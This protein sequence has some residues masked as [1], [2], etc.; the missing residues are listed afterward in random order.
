MISKVSTMER[1]EGP[2]VGNGHINSNTEKVN[3]SNGHANGHTNTSNG[4]TKNSNGH[5]KNSNGHANGSNGHLTTSGNGHLSPGNGQPVSG[6]S[7]T[8]SP[9]MSPSRSRRWKTLKVT[10]IGLILTLGTMITVLDLPTMLI[11]IIK[12]IMVTTHSTL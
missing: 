12:P 11:M 2:H 3:T 9:S 5:A 7:L 1:V 4:H 6:T 10:A 8:P